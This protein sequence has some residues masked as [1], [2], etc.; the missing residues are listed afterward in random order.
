MT[1]NDRL[2]HD[3]VL[4]ICRANYGEQQPVATIE[5]Q[6]YRYDNAVE[7]LR[8]RDLEADAKSNGKSYTRRKIKLGWSRSM[9]VTLCMDS[10][11][12]VK[13]HAYDYDLA[14]VDFQRYCEDRGTLYV[15]GSQGSALW[16]LMAEHDKTRASF[17]ADPAFR[18]A[19]EADGKRYRFNQ[20]ELDSR[21]WSIQIGRGKLQDC[22]EIYRKSKKSSAI[23]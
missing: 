13:V 2:R 22:W 11:L 12:L 4:D 9:D 21:W 10:D 23:I 3:D 6:V 20:K 7:E 14:D 5:D 8:C 18:H 16:A 15:A 19:I 17:M 1:E